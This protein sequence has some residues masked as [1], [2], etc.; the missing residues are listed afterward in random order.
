MPGAQHQIDLAQVQ[1]LH[2]NET[3][4]Q[5]KLHIEAGIEHQKIGNY[6]RQVSPAKRGRGI[7]TNQ[8][9]GCAAQRH[10]FGPG[11]TQFRD[12]A[13]RAL[14]KRQPRGRSAYRMGTANEQLTADRAFQAI[15]TSGYR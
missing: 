2:V 4:D 14:G 1:A 10:R 5:V 7:D 15:D 6:R 8:A 3:V 13:P 11:Q 9:F 12:D